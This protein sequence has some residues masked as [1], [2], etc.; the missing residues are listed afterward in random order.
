MQLKKQQIS[1]NK[2]LRG[3]CNVHE[4]ICIESP[5]AHPINPT[6]DRPISPTNTVKDIHVHSLYSLKQMTKIKPMKNNNAKQCN[7]GE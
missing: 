6:E 4:I 3:E 2:L 5:Y 1:T 7:F